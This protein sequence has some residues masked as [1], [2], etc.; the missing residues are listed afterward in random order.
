MAEQSY[1]LMHKDDVV[2]SLQLDDLSG[3]IKMA[4]TVWFVSAID[5]LYSFF[6]L[7]NVLPQS[8]LD[9]RIQADLLRHCANRSLLVQ[10]WRYA[11]VKAALIG[12][13]RLAVLCFAQ[14]QIIVNRAM[15]ISDKL[16]SARPLI[17]DQCADTENLSEKQAIGFRKLNASDIALI[18]HCIIQINPSCSRTSSSCLT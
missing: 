12:F 17:G 18:L 10:L 4:L 7:R 13:F 2:A 16:G 9:Q 8:I 15:K 11:D 14:R 3:A 1:E 5:L 6:S